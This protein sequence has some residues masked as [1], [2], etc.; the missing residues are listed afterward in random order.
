MMVFQGLLLLGYLYAHRVLENGRYGKAH[1][2]VLALAFAC[3]PIT[4]KVGGAAA[5]IAR[6][7]WALLR[8]IALPFFALSTTSTVLQGWHRRGAPRDEA[9]TYSLYA[10]SN[11]GSLAAL[12]AYPFLLEPRL[13]V[14][15]QIRGWMGLYAVFAALHWPLVPP[16]GRHEHEKPSV[17]PL[18]AKVSW[19]LLSLGPSAALLAATNLLTLDFAAVP[20]LWIVPLA[21]YLSTF[22]LNFKKN[23][24]YPKRLSLAIVFAMLIWIMAVLLTVLY[25]AD[26]SDRWQMLRRLWVVNKFVFINA[27]LFI[28]CLICHRSLARSR[29]GAVDAPRYY[30]LMALGGFLGSVLISLV[31]PVLARRTAMPELDWA[32]AGGL[33][34]FALLFRDWTCGPWEDEKAPASKPGLAAVFLLG[35][36]GL[37][38]YVR[39]SPAFERGTVYSLRN[40]YGYYRV[41]DKEGF[42]RFFHGNTMHGVQYL[43]PALKREPLSYFHRGSPVG[44]MFDELGGGFDRTAILG[45]GVGIL[46]AYGRPGQAIDYYEL[47]PDVIAIARTYFT[48]LEDSPAKISLTSGDARLELARSTG[49]YDLIVLDAFTGGAI[50]VHMLT[51]E[52]FAMYETKLNEGGVIAAHIT[53]RFLN[54]RPELAALARDRGWS[55]AAKQTDIAKLREEKYYSS[56]VIFSRDEKKLAKLRARGW[57]RLDGEKPVR[58]WTDGYASLLSALKS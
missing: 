29:P 33:S 28:L 21:V 54:L 35:A 30:A 4:V 27:C 9:G 47:D 42:R 43:D 41:V 56:W 52:A 13:S 46:A 10:A 12:L 22:I 18:A 7:V 23:P 15:W 45:L 38:F 51:R 36:A 17:T 1:F 53:N 32:L 37:A 6:L 48:F 58:V 40:F 50:P 3:F 44:E 26:L 25:S 49:T 16:A 14:E 57:Q 11:A 39:Q 2:A 8:A 19:L 5:P 20:L 31:M 24:W 34:L 55:L